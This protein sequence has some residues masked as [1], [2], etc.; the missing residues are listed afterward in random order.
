M[1]IAWAFGE[2]HLVLNQSPLRRAFLRLPGLLVRHR[3]QDIAEPEH[4]IV[5]PARMHHPYGWELDGKRLV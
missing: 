2:L 4:L 1:Q 3:T 5:C